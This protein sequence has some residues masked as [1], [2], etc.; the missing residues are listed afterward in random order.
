MGLLGDALEE[1]VERLDEALL[2]AGRRGGQHPLVVA[3]VAH[4]LSVGFTARGRGN[5][6]LAGHPPDACGAAVRVGVVER[7]EHDVGGRRR[8]VVVH[9]IG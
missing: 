9:V 6:A 3:A 5:Y 2:A 7:V 8:P 4:I 1:E